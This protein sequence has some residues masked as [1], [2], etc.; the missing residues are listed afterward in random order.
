[1]DLSQFP[2][3]FRARVLAG[4]V[5]NSRLGIAMR[6]GELQGQTLP[7]HV[8]QE[9][10]APAVLPPSELEQLAR[11]TFATLPYELQIRVG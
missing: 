11:S 9:A 1:M 7:L 10:T 5:R 8:K 4:V 6:F 2:E 3:R